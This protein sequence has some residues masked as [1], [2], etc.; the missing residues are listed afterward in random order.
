[1]RRVIVAAL[2]VAAV[3]ALLPLLVGVYLQH[4]HQRILDALAERGY[5]A[6]A[7]EY[8]LGWLRSSLRTEISPEVSTD[9]EQSRL[10]LMLRLQHGPRVWLKAWP[11]PLATAAGRASVLGAPRALPPLVLGARL[12]VSGAVDATLRVPDLTYSGAAG[13]LHFVAGDAD[14]RVLRD[15][16]WRLHG[17]LQSLEATAPD[18]RRLRVGDI[19][20]ELAAGAA[21]AVLPL[22]RLRLS[23]GS[24]HLDAAAGQP[25]L[26]IAAFGVAL[27]AESSAATVDVAL[28]GAVEELSIGQGF[29]APSA[30]AV[31]VN[32]IDAEELRELCTRLTS[33]DRTALTA[34]QQGMATGRLLLAALPKL[35]SRTPDAQLRRLRLTTPQGAVDA[36]AVL[37][38]AP[39]H[40]PA[41]ADAGANAVPAAGPL[42]PGTLAARLSGS[43]RLSAPQSLVVALLTERQTR[44]VR[45]EL[46]LRGEPADALSPALAADVAAAAQAATRALLRDG[47]LKAEQGRLVADLHLAGGG[48]RV[49]GRRV[50]LPEWLGLPDDS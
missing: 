17:R 28:T 11:P 3:A 42:P 8:R 27:T 18:G 22:S 33:L 37:R 47:W 19:D 9:G 26:D 20:W 30:L 21:S 16:A 45:R 39:A 32:G 34:S 49:N 50:A 31:S 24:L 14:L 41:G 35:L 1:M 15:G 29:Y 25:P 5:R 38:M 43:A 4:R 2:L 23:L 40:G 13:R 48:L 12:R 6:N 44:R 10:R 7:A 36:T 46:A